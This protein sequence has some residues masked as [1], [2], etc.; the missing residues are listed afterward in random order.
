MQLPQLQLGQLVYLRDYSVRGRNKIQDAWSAVIHK[1]VRI[2]E[3]GGVVYS[4]VPFQ[5]PGQVRQVHRVMLKPVPRNLSLATPQVENSSFGS[6]HEEEDVGQ[7]VVVRAPQVQSRLPS[8][9]GSNS[10]GGVTA[11]ASGLEPPVL[12]TEVAGPSSES[13]RRTVR[14]TAGQ[15]SNPHHLPVSAVKRIISTS[16][17]VCGIGRARI[18]VGLSLH[19]RIRVCL[20]VGVPEYRFLEVGVGRVEAV[21]DSTTWWYYLLVGGKKGCSQYT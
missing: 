14:A 9:T 17:K 8:P 21:P 11:E 5:G 3:S 10:L 1:V 4:V 2:P 6:S 19:A 12:E 20:S 15:H 7:W 16:I 18:R 13:K